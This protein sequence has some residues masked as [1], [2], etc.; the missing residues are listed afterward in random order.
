MC[1]IRLKAAVRKFLAAINGTV[2]PPTLALYRHYL[3]RFVDSLGDVRCSSVTP[4]AV[5][6]WSCKYHPAGC[7]RRLFRW[8]TVDARELVVNPLDG[9]RSTRNGSRMRILSRREVDRLLRAARRPFRTFLLAL[10]ETIARPREMRAVCWG[11]IRTAGT[12]DWTAQDLRAGKCYFQLVRFKG[13]ELRRDRL[14]LRTIP[15]SPRLGRL[16]LRLAIA[17]RNVA[18]VIFS[19]SRCR[20]WTWNAVRCQFRRLRVR[21]GIGVDVNG[22]NA[23]AY[24]VRH[25]SA[26]DAVGAGVKGLVLAELMGHSDVRMTQRYVHLRPDHLIE[27]MGRIAEWKSGRAR[28]IDL[29]GSRRKRPE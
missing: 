8:L 10:V 24:S 23:V 2:A 14:A 15:I 20:P 29:P 16:L 27:A 12:A 13:Q 3:E 11:H 6:A 21:A 19:N 26:T 4:A 28:K 18:D 1:Q 9:M 7:V 5:M 22:E 25:T 17:S